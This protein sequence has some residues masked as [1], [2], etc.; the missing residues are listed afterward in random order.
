MLLS[1]CELQCVCFRVKAAARILTFSLFV[2]P[3]CDSAH[4]TRMSASLQIHGRP[5][6]FQK[7]YIEWS[8]RRPQNWSYIW[9]TKHHVP[10]K[11]FFN[12][13]RTQRTPRPNRF[14][15]DCGGWSPGTRNPTTAAIGSTKIDYR[16]GNGNSTSGLSA[17]LGLGSLGTSYLG[18]SA[19]AAAARRSSLPG[20][21]GLGN[22]APVRAGEMSSTKTPIAN[23]LANSSQNNSNGSGRSEAV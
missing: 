7:V 11:Q 2:C 17:A 1:W 16:G 3:I 19:M 23:L 18:P 8:I 6:V 4:D 15:R 5:W 20:T 10:S 21:L 13:P 12:E 14:A 22:S 9:R